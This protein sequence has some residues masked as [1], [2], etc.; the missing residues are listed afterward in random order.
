ML[1]RLP[2]TRKSN[3]SPWFSLKLVRF[4]E[5][6][7]PQNALWKRGIQVSSNV[8]VSGVG[9]LVAVIF[10]HSC[11]ADEGRMNEGEWK[12]G[13]RPERPE[14][15]NTFV[16][17]WAV[18]KDTHSDPTNFEAPV[19]IAGWELPVAEPGQQ[20]VRPRVLRSGVSARTR[21]LHEEPDPGRRH[22][23]H[24]SKRTGRQCKSHPHTSTSA[25]ILTPGWVSE[26]GAYSSWRWQCL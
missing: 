25:V 2:R 4:E 24:A 22:P 3:G 8:W 14:S 15:P 21:E 19:I 9:G 20:A 17:L 6:D 7:K 16:R 26:L 1:S 12:K 10:M 18:N 13:P 23:R 11:Y 5:P